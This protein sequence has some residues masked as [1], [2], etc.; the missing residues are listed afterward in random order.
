M[1]KTDREIYYI[2]VLTRCEG[3]KTLFSDVI[4][5]RNYQLLFF[6]TFMII[7]VKNFIPKDFT[8]LKWFSGGCLMGF[9][10]MLSLGYYC[11]QS[12]IAWPKAIPLSGAYRNL[13]RFC[14]VYY[15]LSITYIIWRFFLLV[16]IQYFIHEV[17]VWKQKSFFQNSVSS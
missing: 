17:S 9:W 14:C 11:T 15:L 6:H 16:A 7:I 3:K 8:N 4:C 1:K 5:L 2:F 12:E 13:K 10:I